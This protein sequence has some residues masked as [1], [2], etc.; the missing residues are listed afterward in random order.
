MTYTL[1]KVHPPALVGQGDWIDQASEWLRISRGVLGEGTLDPLSIK[2]LYVTGLTLDLCLAVNILLAAENTTTITFYSAYA[3][4][5]SAI[6]LLGRCITGNA[7]SNKTTKDLTT[8]FKWLANPSINLY[9]TVKNNDIL[10]ETRNFSYRIS[11]L[12]ALRHFTAHVQAK[13]NLQ[14]GDVDFQFPDDFSLHFDFDPLVLGEFPPILASAI[15]AYLFQLISSES[16][17][18]KLA[19]ASIKPLQSEPIFKAV[20][21][22][23]S[24]GES[25]PTNAGTEIRKMD[26]TYKS[27]LAR[28]GKTLGAA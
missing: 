26:W 19:T 2:A 25:F 11:D 13:I 14:L 18:T 3:V 24:N 16:L 8:G 4:F 1:F 17:S 22:L 27:P 6:E 10:I 7:T 20:W 23:I 9:S 15:E 21:L 28:L 5:A 12:V